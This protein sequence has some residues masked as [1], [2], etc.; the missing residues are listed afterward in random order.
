[1]RTTI[2]ILLLVLYSCSDSDRTIG[3]ERLNPYNNFVLLKFVDEAGNDTSDAIKMKQVPGLVSSYEYYEMISE[4]YSYRCFIDGQEVPPTYRVE[5]G[6]HD[7]E[8]IV[9]L[10]IIKMSGNIKTFY[11][12][13]E[14]AYI[15]YQDSWSDK[16]YEFD[17]KFKLPTL[18]G[19]KENSFK[20]TKKAC[21]IGLP[22]YEKATFNGKEVAP[23]ENH[24][25]NILVNNAGN[26]F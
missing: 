10:Q 12:R 8:S 1:M 19:E 14:T 7:E 16:L 25:F 22:V 6:M 5:L 23:D 24:T 13:L 3:G 18:F 2:I 26:Q 11:F 15:I 20:V 9:E 4:D 21:N 17:Y